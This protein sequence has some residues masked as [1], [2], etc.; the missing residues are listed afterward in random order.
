[1]NPKKPYTPPT[2]EQH[3]PWQMLTGGSDFDIQD[4]LILEPDLLEE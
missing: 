1:M 4:M 3:Q 2:L